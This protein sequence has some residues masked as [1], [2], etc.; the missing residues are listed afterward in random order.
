M[1]FLLDIIFN[2]FANKKIR[3]FRWD[4]LQRGEGNLPLVAAHA[5]FE[6]FSGRAGKGLS[7]PMKC[8]AEGACL[9]HPLKAIDRPIRVKGLA[10]NGN[11]RESNDLINQRRLKLIFSK[12]FKQLKIKNV[13]E[14]EQLVLFEVEEVE[15]HCMQQSIQQKLHSLK[16]D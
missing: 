14:Q 15:V 8:M 3:K 6:I 13:Q 4:F 10:C 2:D 1:K 5:K 9:A 12:I 11:S 7:L 16:E